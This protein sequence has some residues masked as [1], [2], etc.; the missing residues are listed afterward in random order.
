MLKEKILLHHHISCLPESSLAL[1]VM[2]I[3]EKLNLPSLHEEIEAFLCKFGDYDVK[4]YSK[5]KWKKFVCESCAELRCE[6]ILADIKKYK[7]M[8]YLELS[9]DS[10]VFF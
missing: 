4:S 8:Y 1:K 2:T 3:Q 7:K 10:G 5:D 6:R 9:A